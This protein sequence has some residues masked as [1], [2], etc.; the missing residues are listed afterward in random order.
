MDGSR[1][2]RAKKKFI[3]FSTTRPRRI[4]SKYIKLLENWVSDLAKAIYLDSEEC[5]CLLMDTV[6]LLIK[7]ENAPIFICY[8]STNKCS[9]PHILEACLWPL[10][11]VCRD[12]ETHIPLSLPLQEWHS[13]SDIIQKGEG[14]EEEGMWTCS[15]ATVITTIR[16]A[17]SIKLWEEEG[18]KRGVMGRCRVRRYRR[19]FFHGEICGW[20]LKLFVL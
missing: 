16:W 5:P 19:A 15:H 11:Y 1:E 2:E 20:N 12:R 14:E 7:H 8:L 6:N 9:P 4:W 3:A 13:W 10:V 17:Y 18:V